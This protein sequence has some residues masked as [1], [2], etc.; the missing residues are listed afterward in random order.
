MRRYRRARLL[1]DRDRHVPRDAWEIGEELVKRV[2][3][4]KIVEQVLHWH[5]SASEHRNASLDLRVNGN[6]SSLH[7]GT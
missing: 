6:Q 2:S 7:V 5:T 3:R 4:L 1:E